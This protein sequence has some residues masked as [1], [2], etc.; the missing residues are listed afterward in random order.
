MKHGILPLLKHHKISK[1][2][3][4]RLLNLYTYV[5]RFI[6]EE[7]IGIIQSN[8]EYY[9]YTTIPNDFNLKIA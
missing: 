5:Y 6:T 4:N 2:I 8:N 3:L 7:I 9:T 1:Q